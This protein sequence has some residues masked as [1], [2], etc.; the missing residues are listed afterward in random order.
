MMRAVANV[1]AG[2]VPVVVASVRGLAAGF[3]GILY[4]H[5]W[6]YALARVS[7]AGL[8]LPA[9]VLASITL[10]AVALLTRVDYHEGKT[11]RRETGLKEPPA[12][13]FL[14]RLGDR[15]RSVPGTV[16]I[17]SSLMFIEALLGIWGV[18]LAWNM[19]PPD[20]G[21]D[22][23]MCISLSTIPVSLGLFF[24]ARWS[25]GAALPIA[26]L[27]LIASIPAALRSSNFAYAIPLLVLALSSLVVIFSIVFHRGV[28]MHGET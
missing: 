19:S 27:V 3:F 8:V 15:L 12:T 11:S 7:L 16:V 10:A 17:A 9:S 5:L 4:L 21:N 1:L 2:A 20:R 14:D 24:G 6:A 28:L 18:V 23:V 22:F 13:A 26:A 25:A